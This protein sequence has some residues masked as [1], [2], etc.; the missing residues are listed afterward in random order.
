AWRPEKLAAQMQRMT[1][2]GT[3]ACCSNAERI[4][5]A[6]IPGG[7]YFNDAPELFGL[8]QLL[9]VNRVI[10]SSA[11]VKR[12]LVMHVGGF[13]EAPELRAL[14]DYALWLRIAAHTSFAYCPEPLVRYADHPMGSIRAGAMDVNAQRDAVFTDLLEW[15]GNGAFTKGQRRMI[16][17]QLC[18]ARRYAGRP[19]KDWLF[20][21]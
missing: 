21:R 15:E 20:L 5:P 2:A 11:L 6:D 18:R 13:P 7:V 17:R 10:C 8:D 4:L 19:I 16:I 1:R 9:Q 12:E 3:R 14:E